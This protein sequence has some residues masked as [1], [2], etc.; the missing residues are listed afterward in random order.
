[1]RWFFVGLD[2]KQIVGKL[3]ETF[4]N[5]WWKFNIKIDF[6][7]IFG[8][9]DT[10]N[11]AFGNN[12]IFPTIFSVSAGFS[13]FSTGYAPD[14]RTSMQKT[15]QGKIF[16]NR[17][18][19]SVK[20]E[21][22]PMKISLR[23]LQEWMCAYSGRGIGFLVLQPALKNAEWLVPFISK[24]ST[25]ISEKFWKINYKIN[26]KFVQKVFLSFSVLYHILEKYLFCIFHYYLES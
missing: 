24:T 5:F 17:T 21:Y 14:C 9:I 10:K 2:D 16:S 12:I 19:I 26:G 3:W 8:K 23:Q 13:P 20:F 15:E 25:F 1:M 6:F 18:E 11:R 22:F 7:T 4:E